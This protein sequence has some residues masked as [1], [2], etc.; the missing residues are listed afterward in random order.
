VNCANCKQ[1]LEEGARFCGYCGREIQTFSD[2]LAG[3]SLRDIAHDEAPLPVERV[4]ELIRAIAIEVG[5]ASHVARVD[6]RPEV[7]YIDANTNAK[8][9]DIALDA[10]RGDE[11][12]DTFAPRPASSTE[13]KLGYRNAPQV[14][15]TSPEKLMRRVV[16]ERSQVYVIGLL[17]Y[18][19]AVGRL[20]FHKARGPAG[21]ITA[22]LTQRPDAPSTVRAD[23]PR[24]FDTFVL[25]LLHKDPALRPDIPALLA[26]LT[27]LEML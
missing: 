4:I 14:D 20:P 17:A 25:S 5:R 23:I 19:L 15:Y 3:K 9:V 13:D 22:Q 18:E 1:P 27:A 16:D 11:P 6:L 2:V 24:A 21:M 10:V 8:L 26:A 7:I 12:A